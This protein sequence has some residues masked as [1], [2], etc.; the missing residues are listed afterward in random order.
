MPVHVTI[1]A[2]NGYL[3]I[4]SS[5]E[6]ET[7]EDGVEYIQAQIDAA[8]KEKIQRLLVDDRNLT[9]SIDYSDILAL[10]D[11]WEKRGLQRIGL[12]AAAL[13]PPSAPQAQLAYETTATNRSI[14]FK[15]FFDKQEALNW[16]LKPQS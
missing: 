2:M 11:Y 12:R 7:V 6:M 16:L 10:A 14:V 13:A 9:V 3:L 1:T 15:V 4:E 8:L 5:G